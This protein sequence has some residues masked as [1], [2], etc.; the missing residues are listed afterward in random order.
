MDRVAPDG[1]LAKYP[2]RPLLG[3]SSVDRDMVRKLV[4]DHLNR[5]T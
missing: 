3:F 4:L 1:P 5:S 2:A